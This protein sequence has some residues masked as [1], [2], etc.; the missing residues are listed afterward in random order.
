MSKKDFWTLMF[1]NLVTV[2]LL[3]EHLCGL[4]LALEIMCIW[5]S[6]SILAHI[7]ILRDYVKVSKF[8]HHDY[9]R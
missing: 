3:I 6:I 4:C 2:T 9:T 1:C 5:T 8:V 7:S